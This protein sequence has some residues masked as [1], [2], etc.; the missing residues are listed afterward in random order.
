MRQTQMTLPLLTNDPLGSLVSSG[1][2]NSPAP[3]SRTAPA[4]IMPPAA[5]WWFLLSHG[6]PHALR[7]PP[8]RFCVSWQWLLLTCLFSPVCLV[9]FSAD[10]TKTEMHIS[11]MLGAAERADKVNN[12]I[13]DT[14]VGVQREQREGSA[15][16][17]L[18]TASTSLWIS[19]GCT[20]PCKTLFFPHLH[21]CILSPLPSIVEVEPVA[22]KESSCFVAEVRYTK[23]EDADLKLKKNNLNKFKN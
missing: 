2:S 1:P 20:F 16:A 14:N 9:A 3:F 7:S 11:R 10:T 15:H 4:L 8:C 21:S 17:R 5:F 18:G 19:C 22:P 13:Q 23:L 6:A 12:G